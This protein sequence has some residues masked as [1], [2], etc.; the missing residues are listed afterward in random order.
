MH[1]RFRE[2]SEQLQDRYPVLAIE[3][4]VDF[5]MQAKANNKAMKK[6]LDFI[7]PE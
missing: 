3:D 4:I 7:S 2:V 5:E 1:E 6:V